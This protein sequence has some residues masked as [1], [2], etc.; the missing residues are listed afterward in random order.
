MLQRTPRRGWGRPEGPDDTF[1]V[2]QFVLGL[3]V[4]LL[5]VGAF[6][7]GEGSAIT[8]RADARALALVGVVLVMLGGVLVWHSGT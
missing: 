6:A 5:G 7:F 8:G 3:I 4:D 1:R 2:R